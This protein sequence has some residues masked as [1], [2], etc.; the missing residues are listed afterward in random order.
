MTVFGQWLQDWREAC[1]YA[2]E[3]SPDLSLIYPR[4][5]VAVLIV[6]G[7]VCFGLWLWNEREIARS[8]AVMDQYPS[9]SESEDAPNREKQLEELS[10]ILKQTRALNESRLKDVA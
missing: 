1:E 4:E 7:L 2:N 9:G 5:P 3:C 6:I 10:K 8:R